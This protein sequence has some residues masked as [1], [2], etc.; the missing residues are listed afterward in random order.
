MPERSF[1]DTNIL[2]YAEVIDEP[3]KQKQAL[4]LL[5]GLFESSCAVISTQVLQEYCNTAIRKLRL[6]SSHVREQLALFEQF[7]VVQTTPALIHDA[8]DLHQTRS[9]AFY[10]ALIIAAAL[11]AGCAALYTED[12][13]GG[14]R[15]DQL[16]IVNP[17]SA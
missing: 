4:S 16:R 2:V 9:L 12:M 14:E 3:R 11:S 6:S 17:F 7:E 5:R 8:L 10:D 1:I 13:N 15:I